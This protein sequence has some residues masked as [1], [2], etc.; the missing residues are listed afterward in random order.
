MTKL[1]KD[2]IFFKRNFLQCKLLDEE[3]NNFI[4]DATCNGKELWLLSQDMS[5]AY[6]SVNLELFTKALHRI[7][8]PYQLIQILTNLLTNRANQVITNFELTA[9]YQVQDRIDQGEMIIPLL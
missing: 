3:L 4:E 2:N 5:K 1:E 8:M 7:N 9:S 6:D